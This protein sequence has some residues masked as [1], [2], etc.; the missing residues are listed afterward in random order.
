MCDDIYIQN[1]KG[2]YFSMK[3][4]MKSVTFAGPSTAPTTK[5]HGSWYFFLS[6]F[7]F[8]LQK[9]LGW[10]KLATCSGIFRS[11]K[12]KIK[13]STFF[14]SKPKKFGLWYTM[15]IITS[16]GHTDIPTYFYFCGQMKGYLY[17]YISFQFWQNFFSTIKNIF[18]LPALGLCIW[19]PQ[20]I[21]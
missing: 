17:I 9:Q 4:F 7:C 2:T 21:I 19:G 1:K 12:N 10:I 16:N 5:A 6:S 3:G 15:M 20:Y 11:K 14:W 18:Q 8:N 13:I